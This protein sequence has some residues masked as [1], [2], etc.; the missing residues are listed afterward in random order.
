MANVLFGHYKQHLMVGVCIHTCV[1][2]CVMIH[3]ESLKLH[4]QVSYLPAFP[5]SMLSHSSVKLA[6]SC[7]SCILV[8]LSL[9]IQCL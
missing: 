2:L 5:H 7:N 1:F 6:K 9:Q 8:I 3:S 4:G